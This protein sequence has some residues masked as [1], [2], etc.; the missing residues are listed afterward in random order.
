MAIREQTL[1]IGSPFKVGFYAGLGFFFASALMSVLAA[2]LITMGFGAIMVEALGSHTRTSTPAPVVEHATPDQ[3]AAL[4]IPA[5][6][7]Q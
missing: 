4:V 6:D 2:L 1:T 7:T 3:P 5:R